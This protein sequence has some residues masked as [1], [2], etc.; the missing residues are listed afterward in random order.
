MLNKQ[1]IAVIVPDGMADSEIAALGGRTP[2]EAAKKPCMDLLARGGICGMAS[3]I[4]EKMISDASATANLAILGYNPKIYSKGRS[5]LE[6]ASLGLI[7]RGRDTAFRCNLATLSEEEQIYGDKI[8][9]DHG[10]DEI[11]TEEA[12]ILIKDLDRELGSDK[13]RFFTGKSYR[14]IV[15]W[16]DYPGACDFTGP[17]DILTKRAGG[18]LP[19]GPGDICVRLM[20]KSYDL[21]NCHPV[22]SKRRAEKK[23]PANSI[24]LWSPGTKPEIPAFEMKYG[25]KGSVVAFVDLIKGLGIY[26]GMNVAEVEGATGNFYTNYQNKA[27]AAIGE[28]EKGADFVFVHIEAPDECAHRKEIE[29][30]V[31]S[32]E[33]IDEMIAAPLYDYLNSSF[34]DFKMLILPDHPTYLSTGAHSYDPVPFLAYKK[35]SEK[36]SKITN[37]NEKSVSKNSDIFMQNGYELLDFVF[38]Q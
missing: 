36:K 12:D 17:H 9:I 28:F 32:I 5:P 22:N 18:Y 16:E 19:F 15:L 37:F 1:K 14:H 30:K 20:E 34:K 31:K 8:I 11:S 25:Q 10:A 29:N 7:M 33:N 35:G 3:F 24:W 38:A 21:L 4:P 27:A 26:A 2:M 23:R 13:V 6:A